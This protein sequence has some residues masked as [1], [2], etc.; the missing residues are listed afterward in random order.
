M[1]ITLLSWIIILFMSFSIG[2]V[3]IRFIAP[4]SFA[5]TS[6]FDVYVVAGILCLNVYAQVYSIFSNVRTT[7]FCLIFAIAV[8]CMI[9]QFVYVVKN[10]LNKPIGTIQIWQLCVMF[11]ITTWTGLNTMKAPAFGDTYLYHAQA[12]RWIEEYGVVP[13][14]GNLH[15]RFAY[16]SACMSLHALFSF[17][18][19]FEQ[20]LHAVNG[21]LGCFFVGYAL[22]TNKL[23]TKSESRLSD[24]LKCAILVYVFVSRINISSPGSDMPAML[25]ILYAMCKWSECNETREDSQSFGVICLF[26]AWAVSIKL[27]AAA[28]MILILYPAVMLIKE[29]RWKT[30]LIDLVAGIIIVVPWLVRNVIISGYLLYPYSGIDLFHFDWK[31]PVEM[32]DYDRKEIMVWGREIKDVSRFDESITQW[33]GT[34]FSGQML[35]NKIFIIVGFLATLILIILMLIKLI[36]EYRN[37]NSVNF[38]L[39][40]IPE[41][42]LIITMIISE[43]FWLFSAPLVRYGVVYLLMPAAAVVYIIKEFMGEYRFRRLAAIGTVFLFCLMFL[44]DDEDFRLITPHGYWKIDNVKMDWYGFEIYRTD[45]VT[46]LSGYDDFP[47]VTYERVLEDIVPR[48]DRLEDG[49]KVRREDEY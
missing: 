30:I 43:V 16:N 14:L 11:V 13:G 32:L 39:T 45:Q 38:F 23:F 3:L 21:F 18:W 15:S 48:G 1:I 6:N 7:A 24:M 26:A 42:L 34:W 9:Y 29:K 22:I 12:I 49:F 25:I 41:W 10:A 46:F 17:S 19:Y 31:I 28:C 40:N 27:S 4:N 47:V 44:R 20:P 33:F 37:R 8:L 5:G 2:R 36:D 35:R